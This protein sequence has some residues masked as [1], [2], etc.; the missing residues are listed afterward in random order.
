MNVANLQLEGLLMSVASINNLLVHK[1]VLSI[2]EIDR[3]LQHAEDSLLDDARLYEDMSPSNRDAVCF[4]LRLLQLANLAQS[5]TEIPPF[6]ELA[7]MVAELKQ[8]YN[9]KG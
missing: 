7:R 9:E 1:G 5:E 2:D 8:P 6:S 3:A 4:P